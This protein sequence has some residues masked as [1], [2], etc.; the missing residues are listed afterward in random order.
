MLEYRTQ[1]IANIVESDTATSM[2]IL[3]EDKDFYVLACK[4]LKDVNQNNYEDKAKQLSRY[5]NKRLI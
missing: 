4:L 1:R 3:L 2:S 5:A